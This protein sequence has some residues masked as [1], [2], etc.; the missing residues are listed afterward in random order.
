MQ[1][2]EQEYKPFMDYAPCI[3]LFCCD[4]HIIDAKKE[5]AQKLK[6]QIFGKDKSE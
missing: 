1:F 4:A 3:T 5:V 6:E 2:I